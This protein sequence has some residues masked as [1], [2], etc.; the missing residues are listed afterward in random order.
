MSGFEMVVGLEV[1]IELSTRTKMFCGCMN[2]FG[3]PPNTN[4]C[5]VCMGL[6]GALPVPNRAAVE[7]A[8]RLALALGCAIAPRSK[9]D[10]KNYFYPDLPKGYQISQLDEPLG[11]GGE[12]L[13]VGGTRV[14]IARLQLEEDAGKLQHEAGQA[15]VDFNR[16]GVPLV[17]IVSEPDIRS[18]QDARAYWEE[19]RR[20]ALYLGVTDAR[21]EE[22][23]VRADAN[24]SLRPEGSEELNPRVEIKNM[25]SFRH[26]ERALSYEFERQAAV[27]RSGGRVLQETRGW[28]DAKGATFSQRSKEEAQDYRYFPEPDLLP[29]ELDA[30][31]VHALREGLPVLPAVRRQQLAAQGL[32]EE[33]VRLIAEDR[34]RAEYFAAV[35][36]AG[37]PPVEAA[38]WLTGEL[39]RL[40]NEGRFD[41][42][43]PRADA[44]EVAALIGLVAGGK[45]TQSAA[46][47]ALETLA[48][49]GGTARAVLESLGLTQMD[50]R[51]AVRSEVRAVLAAE[52]KAL[53]DLRSG[54]EKALSFLVGQVMRRTRGRVPADLAATL[55]REEAGV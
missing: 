17:E 37:A 21:M 8:V 42:A 24:I 36:A 48:E 30:H 3:M 51:E 18:A 22:G 53:L 43:Q 12:V 33:Q 6:P 45:V 1:H 50:D 38:K 39:L 46:K 49:Q 26:L 10:R 35:V 54:K 15:I 31:W 23:S 52:E 55:I 5:P 13:L 25:N 29:F 47:T 34:L 2:S 7:S 16:A 27:Y 32:S 9:F 41:F 20:I 11:Q 4:V 44:P 19:I 40:E 28:D 14:R